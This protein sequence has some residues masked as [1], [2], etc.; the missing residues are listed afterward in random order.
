[1]TENTSLPPNDG[2]D[3]SPLSS[4][5]Q[6]VRILDHTLK[7]RYPD[8]VS[9]MKTLEGGLVIELHR[10]IQQPFSPHACARADDL[11]EY[12]WLVGRSLTLE[13]VGGITIRGGGTTEKFN[14]GRK[15]FR[16]AEVEYGMLHAMIA[17]ALGQ[18][19]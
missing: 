11:T 5:L 19:R 18:C 7:S 6:L 9:L 12:L 14:V 4:E 3:D 1:V 10:Q 2:M 17:D 13:P 8:G 15:F 16:E